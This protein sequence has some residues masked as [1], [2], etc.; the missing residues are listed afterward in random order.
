MFRSPAT[1]RAILAFGAEISAVAAGRKPLFHENFLASEAA[2]KE[3]AAALQKQFPDL[4]VGHHG[5]SIFV[6]HPALIE[7]IIASDPFHYGVDPIPAITEAIDTDGVGEMLGY[8][9]RSRDAGDSIVEIWDTNGNFVA[10][11]VAN[12]ADSE[13]I[14]ARV[15]DYSD[16]LGKPARAQLS[17]RDTAPAFDETEAARKLTEKEYAVTQLDPADIRDY[18]E[19]KMDNQGLGTPRMSDK[20]L[21]NLM[22]F[23]IATGREE[24]A[25]IIWSVIGKR[26]QA[27]ELSDAKEAEKKGKYELLEAVSLLGGFPTT[28]PVLQEEIDRLREYK[29][30]RA[31]GRFRKDASPLDVLRRNLQDYGFSFETPSDLLNAAETRFS[32]G[33]KLYGH[34]VPEELRSQSTPSPAEKA[35]A[36]SALADLPAAPLGDGMG[37]IPA[38]RSEAVAPQLLANLG[39]TDADLA[40]LVA[41]DKTLRNVPRAAFQEA[42][43]AGKKDVRAAIADKTSYLYNNSI[44]EAQVQQVQQMLAERGL[45]DWN[46]TGESLLKMMHDAQ[47]AYATSLWEYL[48]NN[49][50]YSTPQKL[51]VFAAFTRETATQRRDGKMQY[52]DLG[53]TSGKLPQ[54]HNPLLVGAIAQRLAAEPFKGR[55]SDLV[56]QEGQKLADSSLASKTKFDAETETGEKGQWVVF[57][58]GGDGVDLSQLSL[59]TQNTPCRGWCI[60]AGGTA[61]S[62][63]KRGDMHLFVDGNGMPRA[64][65]LVVDGRIEE[66]R[67][68]LQ[69][70]DLEVSMAPAVLAYT[71][72]LSLE[73]GS[74]TDEAVF[75]TKANEAINK[76]ETF[77]EAKKA[78]TEIADEH[79]YEDTTEV[80]EDLPSDVIALPRYISKTA[81]GNAPINLK[82]LDRLLKGKKVLIEI[83][84]QLPEGAVG[85]IADGTNFYEDGEYDTI[86]GNVF[87]H[88]GTVKIKRITGSANVLGGTANVE[89]VETHTST[90]G[91][92]TMNVGT[93]GGMASSYGNSTMNQN[94]PFDHAA[95][96]KALRGIPGRSLQGESLG[97]LSKDER[98][99]AGRAEA[100]RRR[101]LHE[102]GETRRAG[103]DVGETAQKRFAKARKD[104]EQAGAK[105]QE[106][107]QTAL[108][109]IYPQA[110]GDIIFAINPKA[111]LRAALWSGN[112]PDATSRFVEDTLAEEWFHLGHALAVRERWEAGGK[113]G[114]FDAYFEKVNRRVFDSISPAVA[115]LNARNRK[116]VEAALVSSAR[117]YFSESVP[118]LERD[119]LTWQETV[120]A[121]TDAD[122]YNDVAF[123]AEFLRQMDQLR[124]K[125][126][127]TET[128]FAGM[129]ARLKA[130]VNR[131]LD[132]LRNLAGQV[133]DGTLGNE[134]RTMSDEIEAK[135]QRMDAPS[136]ALR[137]QSAQT[138][139][140]AE[141]A[142]A[143]ADA[144]KDFESLSP[145]AQA[146]LRRVAAR[147]FAE[148][149]RLN[150]EALRAHDEAGNPLPAPNGEPSKLDRRQW[151]QVRTPLFKRWFGDWE[152]AEYQ[153]RTENFIADALDGIIPQQEMVLRGVT[154][155]EIR[156]VSRQGGPDISGMEHTLDAGHLRHALNQHSSH[157]EAEKQKGQRPLTRDDLL[158]V[159]EILNAY[160]FLTVRKGGTNS[161]SLIHGKTYPDGTVEYVERVL[162]T[163]GKKKPRLV[164]RTVWAVAEA[165]V[166]SNPT[167]VYTPD[168]NQKLPFAKGRVNPETVSKVVDANGEP[169]VVYHG[170]PTGGF[171]TFRN[172]DTYF[173]EDEAA[174]AVY[175]SHSASSIRVATEQSG[176]PATYGVFLNIRN[177]FDTRSP[178][179][180]KEF[181]NEFFEKGG[182][183]WSSN[184]TKLTEHSLPDWTDGRDLSD[185]IKET[186]RPYEAVRLDEGSL[187]QMDGT[188]RWR[189][190]SWMILKP[191]GGT[192]KSA[193]D[194][195][196]MFSQGGNIR[197]SRGGEQSTGLTREAVAAQIA[198]EYGIRESGA[199]RVVSG[200]EAERG[201]G[202]ESRGG[203]K[204]RR[205]A[206]EGIAKDGSRVV[207][208]NPDPTRFSLSGPSPIA[209]QGGTEYRPRNIVKGFMSPDFAYHIQNDTEVPDGSKVI[210]STIF[211]RK[212]DGFHPLFRL[213]IIENQ[214]GGRYV[215]VER[216]ADL[217]GSNDGAQTEFRKLRHDDLDHFRKLHPV[218]DAAAA[219]WEKFHDDERLN[220]AQGSFGFSR[221]GQASRWEGRSIFNDQGN[222]IRIELNADNLHSPEDVRRVMEHELGHAASEKGTLRDA[223]S[224]LSE[225]ERERIAADMARLGYDAADAKESDARAVD[226][227]REAWRGRTWFHR[228]VAHIYALAKKAGLKLSDEKLRLLAERAAVRAVA[229]EIRKLAARGDQERSLFRQM[230][231]SLP[232]ADRAR[233]LNLDG[234]GYLVPPDV[235][236]RLRADSRFA[237][238]A[239]HGT[240]HEI[241]GRMSLNKIGSGEGTSNYV[242]FDESKIRITHRNGE[243]VSA[244][245]AGVIV[246]HS[247]GERG[248]PST[249]QPLTRSDSSPDDS[250]DLLR[251]NDNWTQAAWL[252]MQFP[253]QKLEDIPHTKLVEKM[254]EWRQNH[255]DAKAAAKTFPLPRKFLQGISF[256][257]AGTHS[258][259]SRRSHEAS[260]KQTGESASAA[261]LAQF[262][263]AAAPLVEAAKAQGREFSPKLLDLVGARGGEHAVVLMPGRVLKFTEPDTAGGVVSFKENGE[264]QVFQG[265]LPDYLRQIETNRELVNDDTQ[266]EGVM[267]DGEGRTRIVT[268]QK[269]IYGEKPTYEEAADAFMDA[270]FMPVD[271]EWK[272]GQ[273]GTELWW[274][275]EKNIGI[276]DAK[277]D[278]LA[279]LD[280][281][282]I[283]FLDIKA[284]RPTGNALEWM[285]DHADPL[286]LAAHQSRQFSKRAVAAETPPPLRSQPSGHAQ[287]LTEPVLLGAELTSMGLLAQN[288]AIAAPNGEN[289][290]VAA[291]YP[292]GE[293][294]VW[295]VTLHGPRS[296]LAT[297]DHL[298][299]AKIQRKIHGRF[300]QMIGSLLF[301]LEMPNPPRR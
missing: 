52:I 163:S 96:E 140:A 215:Q 27:Q 260:L 205:N 92:G 44:P 234:G 108:A 40:T 206:R 241:E 193:T 8:G 49:P 135:L 158:R 290:T 97:V 110:N 115:K 180:K 56:F 190:A 291:I 172:R 50:V 104:F 176:A 124:A 25:E 238:T 182:D 13:T 48:E 125:N 132:A 67:G 70:Q 46:V 78:L 151:V 243:P 261:S 294:P 6:A 65:M 232:T 138:N 146:R 58:K 47:E 170:T 90:Y 239:Y 184:G 299:A 68:V 2:A 189:G 43:E 69:G 130:W 89:T 208:F 88:S 288:Q 150:A 71:D 285:K 162:E 218:K 282:S 214:N 279:K 87:V 155:H 35:A 120:Q 265:T 229:A 276:A 166:K 142:A 14:A 248:G 274:N 154:P 82:G 175:Q 273:E 33:Q 45:A 157:S 55:L 289:A 169:M 94:V 298:W 113:Q 122:A 186:G 178:Q 224:K 281:G 250:A 129:L 167:R 278:N 223:I 116:E 295:R 164:T 3:A 37:A 258:E 249:D 64:G 185:W 29:S 91:D 246:R 174:A 181:Q 51:L 296:T 187:P 128:G 230:L 18:V 119:G 66:L 284:F 39:I 277:P 23:F 235:N 107:S 272:L 83:G 4:L 74:W 271:Q 100:N 256:L 287:P 160:D 159:P 257:G 123:V 216:A 148:V 197:Y 61:E 179:H 254:A 191:G 57:P 201:S 141:E 41:S 161:A 59:R 36:L 53:G 225:A 200:A 233:V 98:D 269:A 192:T 168:R 136:R 297:A 199:F 165:G 143:M 21:E 121:L 114:A 99:F 247:R 283:E 79:G 28:D 204:A 19:A 266:P 240:P 109:G 244:T 12:K 237:L 152:A 263:A 10:G 102:P 81:Y 202:R 194:N 212:I 84:D 188:L 236:A 75:K 147:Q 280:D 153:A 106:T 198:K 20:S 177:I 139:P 221:T 300:R 111:G 26:A 301:I 171:D 209:Y 255:P 210:A 267:T 54:P 101:V 228:A 213:S 259:D 30:A 32:T 222:L 24:E 117:L 63:L 133:K 264:P 5:T 16:A 95:L 245:E 203:A 196:G 9:V 127:I 262:R 22:E 219:F 183:E 118:A 76:A 126:N 60:G 211:K 7:E 93:V 131:A 217:V 195:D 34:H 105:I 38:G 137:S 173:H 156:E 275:R 293:Q 77:E 220:A 253:G 103:V 270:G 268:S 86:E 207:D 227:L 292:Q 149:K 226:A 145:E 11:F 85:W 73:G 42:V 251:K 134:I 242:I 1:G 231:V 144:E 31:P 252:K 15:Q 112:N 286:T 72:H 62:Y 17:P 80:P